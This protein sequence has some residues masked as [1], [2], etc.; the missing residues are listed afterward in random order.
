MSKYWKTV[1][2]IE[3]LSEGDEPPFAGAIGDDM[4]SLAVI[5]YQIE[6]GEWSGVVKVHK[7]EEVTP[8]EMAKLLLAE[9]SDPEFLGLKEDGSPAEEDDDEGE[10]FLDE[11]DD[12]ADAEYGDGGDSEE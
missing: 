11:I 6:H 2:Q 12:I 8:V 4:P 5:E 10:T 9:G 7:Q 1:V 3:I